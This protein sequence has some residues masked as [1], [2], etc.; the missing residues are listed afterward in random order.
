MTPHQLFIYETFCLSHVHYV[1]LWKQDTQLVRIR[2]MKGSTNLH[3]I[4]CRTF[5]IS[6]HVTDLMKVP[7]Y[8]EVPLK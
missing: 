3:L 6:T 2:K 7:S 1:G 4:F 5:N 8:L